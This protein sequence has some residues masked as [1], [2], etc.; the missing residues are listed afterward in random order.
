MTAAHQRLLRAETS[1]NFYWGETWVSRANRDL[2]EAESTLARFRAK[3]YLMDADPGWIV[4]G[5][6]SA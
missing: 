6:Q 4:P 2:D 3:K 5:L 1:C